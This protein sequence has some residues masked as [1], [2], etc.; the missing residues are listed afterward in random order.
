MNGRTAKRP[1][2]LRFVRAHG[3][4]WSSIGVG[5]VVFGLLSATARWPLITRLLAGWDAG[6][7]CYI[8]AAFALM[9][10]SSLMELK[11]HSAA[12]DEGAF[13]LLVLTIA[14]AGASFGAIFAELGALDRSQEG[15]GLSVALAVATIVLSWTFTHLI[16]AFHYAYDY[17]GSGERAAGLRFPDEDN[18]G[19]SDFVYFAFVIGMTFQVSD[20]AVT[21][22]GIRRVVVS[23]GALSFAFATTILALTVNVAGA[24]LGSGR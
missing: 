15:Y 5:V 12:Q 18:P 11:R 20:V 13:A 2:W 16:F 9:A 10:R 22:R 23:H 1:R 17:Y 19:Y 14:A 4:L 6:V 21:H 3:R 24:L 8:A 7:A